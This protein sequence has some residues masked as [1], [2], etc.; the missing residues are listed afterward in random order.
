MQKQE[1][2]LPFIGRG[3]MKNQDKNQIHVDVNY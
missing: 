1:G 3:S 2:I